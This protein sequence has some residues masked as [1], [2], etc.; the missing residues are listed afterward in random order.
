MEVTMGKTSSPGVEYK[1]STE[2]EGL[3]YLNEYEVSA[4]I[5]F[6]VG[7]LRNWRSLGRGPCYHKM[8]RAVR[9]RLKD[10]LAWVESQRVE[11]RE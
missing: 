11:T 7:S 2:L 1:L 5:G 9:Y 10:I 4:L 3:R 6:A 8:G